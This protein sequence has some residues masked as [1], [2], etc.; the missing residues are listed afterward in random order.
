MTVNTDTPVG[1]RFRDNAGF[2]R[3]A[4]LSE[5]IGKN[6]AYVDRI[7]M[8]PAKGVHKTGKGGFPLLIRRHFSLFFLKRMLA[9]VQFQPWIAWPVVFH[10]A[11]SSASERVGWAAIKLSIASVVISACS[12]KV[13]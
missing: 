13:P 9:V 3:D 11:S 5:E 10:T 7:A 2:S 4:A 1:T 6:E 12:I 8:H